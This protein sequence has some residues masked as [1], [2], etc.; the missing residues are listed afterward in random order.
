MQVTQTLSE[1][2]KREFKVVLPASELSAK[3]QSQ[4]DELKS[5]AQI[6]GFRPGKAP[7][8]YL[9]RVYGKGLM[10]EVLQEAVDEA[11]R[12]IVEEHKLRIAL[13]PRLDFPGGQAEVEKALEAE[14]DFSFLV[15]FETLPEIEIGSFD[16]ISLE[17]PV[18]EV[19]EADVAKALDGLLERAR[20]FEDKGEG[21]KAEKGDKVTI[22]FTGTL[23]GVPFEGGT[24]GDVDLLLGSGS[25]I[26]GF[27]EQLEGAAVGEQRLVK[28][29]FP[30]DYGAAS[31]AGR[32]AEFDVTVKALAAAKAQEIDDAFAKKFGFET[33]ADLQ[34][35]IRSNIE[36]DYAKA[37]RNKLKRALLDALDRKFSFELP[38]GL[39]DREF[40]G[41]W[42][43]LNNERK[44]AG[45]TFEED[46][47]SEESARAEYR[48]IA[49][50]RVRLGLVLAEI[51][52]GAGVKIEDKDVTDAL[53]ERA[54][55]FPGQEQQV[56]DYYRNNAQALAQIRAPLYEERVVDHLTSLIKITDKPVPREELFAEDE[57]EE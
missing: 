30:D 53:V 23:D 52:Q 42:E 54:R 4:L 57:D 46:G 6:K 11:N 29:R 31:L 47:K 10:G 36:A 37:S 18:T 28:V 16:D 15:A 9:K 43:Q 50:R 44:R 8:S 33:V 7:T 35:A 55:A 19:S 22:D 34:N 51:G 27:E 26:P 49:E 25:F 13:E 14:G 39:V 20:E 24:G 5:K 32:D 38:Q 2:L 17:R 40:S 48:T 3:L 45:K 41:I 12:K 56:W 1:G 21:A